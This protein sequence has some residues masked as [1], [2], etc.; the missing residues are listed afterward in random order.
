MSLPNSS[1]LPNDPT[2]TFGVATTIQLALL[3]IDSIIFGNISGGWVKLS[4]KTITFSP[5]EDLISTT[6]EIDCRDKLELLEITPETESCCG[7]LEMSC[8]NNTSVETLSG[9]LFLILLI[10]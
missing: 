7:P 2:L 3:S 1:I 9:M 4:F 10:K 6:L 5:E 8:I